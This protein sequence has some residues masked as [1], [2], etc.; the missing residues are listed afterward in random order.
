[1]KRLGVSPAVAWAAYDWA[2]SAFATTVMAAFFPVFFKMT[3]S[4]GIDPGLTTAR[5]GLANSVGTLLVALSAPLLG[6]LADRHAKRKV[7]LV[8]SAAMGAGLTMALAWV[9]PGGWVPALL[10]YGAATYGFALSLCFYD[11]LLPAIAPP[12]QWDRVSAMGF[13]FGYLGGG[14]LFLVNI[15]MYR[16]PGLFGLTSGD[17]AIRMSFVLVGLWWMLFTVPLIWLVREPSGT[18]APRASPAW[19]ELTQT[20]RSLRRYAPIFLFLIGFYF[21]NDGV[22]TVMK[23][24][25]DYGLSIGIGANHLV[26]ALLMVQFIGFP[27][28]LAVGRLAE[29]TGSRRVIYGCM[30][31]Y[32][33]AVLWASRIQTPADYFMLAALVGCVQGG[34][35]AISRSYYA[36][37]VPKDRTAQ[38]FGLYG[39]MGKFSGLLGPALVGL[40]G[41]GAGNARVGII[42]LVPLFLAGAFFLSRVKE[43]NR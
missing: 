7:F 21:Y 39:L 23:M 9:P 34:I 38:F 18:A 30:G 2:N 28:T 36:R 1:M 17:A 19:Q 5:F 29:R 22:G 37:L 3:A 32:V 33:A 20:F 41:L 6:A 24:A 43:E 4:A 12:D 13:A 26:T 16:S 35:Q 14:L 27:A 8:A 11:S 15:L 10:L 42:S 25:T 40:V 31:A